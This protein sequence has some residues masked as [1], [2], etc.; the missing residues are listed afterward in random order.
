MRPSSFPP[1]TYKPIANYAR[2]IASI[3]LIAIILQC[4]FM[5]SVFAASAQQLTPPPYKNLAR[6]GVSVVRL[7]VTYS[8]S[9][10]G[11]SGAG[12]AHLTP[13]PTSRG[14]VTT[15]NPTPPASFQCT[16]LGV[17]V[18]SWIPTGTTNANTLNLTDG[19][20]VQADAAKCLNPL[21][22]NTTFARS[23]ITVYF[24]S[25]YNNRIITATTSTPIA[26]R[27][28]N[29]TTCSTSFALFAVHTDYANP[30]ITTTAVD[31]ASTTG[32]EL[33][34][35]AS[36]SSPTVLPSSAKQDQSYLT[37]VKSNVVP[38]LNPTPST[39][40]SGMPLV[41][42]TGNLV[43]LRLMNQ[44]ERSFMPQTSTHSSPAS[45]NGVSTLY[46]IAILLRTIGITVLPIFTRVRH[47]TPQQIPLLV[48][49]SRQI[50]S[51][52][53]RKVL[54]TRR[55]PKDLSR[56]LPLRFHSSV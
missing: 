3:F 27:C 55:K 19:N 26:V 49:R 39:G 22:N 31:T 40:E 18:A 20:L 23:S 4:P 46:R 41:D 25:A 1:H 42:T 50:S 32:I 14:T 12:T 38:S 30:F 53:E 45:L 9:S 37:A 5:P 11:G 48:M 24:S 10:D 52:W 28:A 6:V 29:T 15:T 34:K 16:G 33:T 56:R 2:T 36:S 44:T 47:L 51:S 17:V 13:T 21:P 54:R 8:S 35:S 7:V 43:S